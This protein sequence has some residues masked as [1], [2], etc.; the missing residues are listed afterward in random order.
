MSIF[1]KKH[2]DF[3]SKL[4]PRTPALS[5]EDL[6]ESIFIFQKLTLHQ[7]RILASD[8]FSTSPARH[9][10]PSFPTNYRVR[11]QRIERGP[12]AWTQPAR[13]TLTTDPSPAN[14]RAARRV[15]LPSTRSTRSAALPIY[16]P[17]D[18]PTAETELPSR[19]RQLLLP[20]RTSPQPALAMA[21]HG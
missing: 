16:A 1:Y 4:R 10:Q 2:I 3:Y 14:L 20:V 8:P 18:D 9:P 19:I 5:R 7:S 17:T 13:L 15:A 21:A 12:K 6:N 11:A